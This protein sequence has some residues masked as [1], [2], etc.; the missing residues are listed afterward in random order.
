[1]K[2]AVAPNSFRGSL[3]TFEVAQAIATG[4]RQ[5]LPQA[6]IVEVPV[7]DGGEFTM[8]VLMHALGGKTLYA[9]VLGPLGNLVTAGYSILGDGHTAVIEMAR[10]SGIGL[11]PR[12]QL[13]PM[14]ATSYG[15][16]QLIKAALDQG[17]RK[18]IIGLGGSATV[19]GGAGM[20]QALGIGLLNSKG[21]QIGYG[22]E[23]LADLH[24]IDTHHM[25]TRLV[26]AKIVVA[27]DIDIE[28]L[29]PNG[30]AIMFG[31]QKGAT[32]QM[33]K[34]LDANLR[35]FAQIIL[36]DMQCDVTALP[37]GGASG[38]LGAAFYAFIKADL[39][40]GID[41]ILDYLEFERQ[42]ADCNLVITG[43]GKIDL[44][45]LRGKAPLGVAQVAKRLGIPVISIVGIIDKEIETADFSAFDVIVPIADR[46]MPQK[47]SMKLAPALI[48]DAARRTAKLLTIGTHLFSQ[49]KLNEQLDDKVRVDAMLLP[50]SGR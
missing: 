2:I 31:P 25:D 48:A 3:S 18:V 34:Q 10:A 21:M 44:Q 38:G 47:L 29:G 43:E 23:A 1:M 39:K 49:P 12:R 45:T 15:T 35:S 26:E 50:E 37:Y 16:G 24:H 11:I 13:N 17:C 41:L 22:G 32:R 28:L 36:R 9:E 40:R 6:E 33:A 20:L 5:V 7:A 19:D 8:D 27:C 4:L 42:L 46:P 30:A 14:R